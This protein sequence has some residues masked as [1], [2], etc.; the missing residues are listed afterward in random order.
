MCSSGGAEERIIVFKITV[1]A[2][3]TFKNE[4]PY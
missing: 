4:L 2:D 1:S 3:I